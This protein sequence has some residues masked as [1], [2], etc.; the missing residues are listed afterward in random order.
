MTSP[1]KSARFREI[2]R[3]PRLGLMLALGFSSGL[4]FLLIF[5]TQSAWLREAGVSRSAI[6]LMSYAA[7]AFSFKFAWAPIFDEY[8]PPLVGVWLGRRRGWMLLAQLGVAAGLSG[9]AFGAPAES[10]RWSVA[11]AFLT[12]FAAASQDVTIDGWRIDAAPIERQGMMS[13]V[14][15]LGYRLA[16]LC[17]GAG[18]LYIADFM[19]WRAAY[20]AMAGLTLVGIGSCLVSPR[21]DRPRV[22]PSKR[23]AS[24]AVAF[25]EPLGDLLRRYGP[26][27]IAI[28]VLVAIYRLPD[29]VSGVMANSLYI[30][31]G[32]TKSDIA[33][34]SKLYGVWIGIA[35]A[36]GGGLAVARLGL[37]PSLI[38]GG[39][40]A[41]SS[42]LTLALLAAHGASLPL[43]TLSVS[44]ELRLRLRRRGSDRLHVVARL[45]RVRR[46]PMRAFVL[47]ICAARQSHRRPVGSDG[48][49]VRLCPLPPRHCGDRHS[50]GRAEPDGVA[51]AEAGGSGG[52]GL[53]RA[54][55]PPKARA[56]NFRLGAA[57]PTAFQSPPVD[58]AGSEYRSRFYENLA[59]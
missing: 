45:A 17:A 51:D 36:F 54:L 41:S 59:L 1:R 53:S 16:V 58:S 55:S 19:S 26:A 57:E 31:L 15:Q 33:T 48:R 6:G 7:L 14:Y 50:R 28:L 49:R 35:G 13:A 39:L 23:A 27:L 30:D 21:L 46:D 2:L 40:A 5:S 3:D 10:L 8:D 34:V 42:H 47:V 18:A 11:F 38:L 9:L 4:P 25:V 20:L 22:G 29:F 52:A 44:A 32:F 43:L 24:F 12:A 56:A 37:M